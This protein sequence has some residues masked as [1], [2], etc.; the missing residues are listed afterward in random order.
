MTMQTCHSPKP[1]VFGKGYGAHLAY[2]FSLVR[3]FTKLAIKL[4]INAFVPGVYYEKAHWTV[5]DLYYKMS[6]HRHGT[7][8]PK[9]C[10]QCG[11]NLE[12]S[13]SP[14]I[15]PVDTT[16]PDREPKLIR[17]DTSEEE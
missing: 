2:N 3:T 14:V 16:G 13:Q 15:H 8:D 5:I 10:D 1:R 17:E 11:S 6:G 12:P 7:N 9:R 4:F